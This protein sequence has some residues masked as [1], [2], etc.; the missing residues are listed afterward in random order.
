MRRPLGEGRQKAMMR[1][2]IGFK[3]KIS[4]MQLEPVV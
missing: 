4:K 1:L 3:S 2:E